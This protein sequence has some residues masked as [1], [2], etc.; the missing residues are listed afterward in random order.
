[1]ERLYGKKENELKMFTSQLKKYA[2]SIGA[3]LV[4]I[5]DP[6]R[7]ANAPFN[8]TPHAL[9]PD[10]TAAIVM[11]FHYLDTCV[12]LGGQPDA[13]YPGPAVS[14][15]IASEHANYAAFK[16]CKYIENQ[17]YKALMVPATGWWNYRANE[18]SPR[19]FAADITHYYA[20]CAAGLGEIGWNNICMTPEFGPRQRWITVVTNAPLEYDPMYDGNKLCDGCKLCERHCPGEVFSKESDGTITIDFVE[21]SYTFKHKNLWRCAL[22]ENFQLDSFMDRPEKSDEKTME[23]LCED[24]AKGGVEKRFSWKMGMCL[25]WC[26]THDRR[27]FDRNFTSSPRRRRDVEADYTS[28]GITNAYELLCETSRKIGISKVIIFDEDTLSENGI[29]LTQYVSTA[30][31]AVSVIQYYP[32]NC[33]GDTTRQCSRNALWL[34]KVLENRGGYDTM[35]E[36]GIDH[37]QVASMCRE[38]ISNMPYKIHTIITSIPFEYSVVDFHSEKYGE[39]YA[40][41]ELSMI[42]KNIAVNNGADLYGVSGIDRINKAAAQINNIIENEDYF[43]SVEQGWGEKANRMIDMKGKPKNPKVVDIKLKA[44]TTDDYM[45][46]AKAVIVIGLSM[47]NG[48]VDNVMQPPAYKGAH[49]GATVHKEMFY[50]NHEIALNVCK[51]LNAN[52]YKAHITDDL[53]DISSVTYSFGLP[54]IR[55]NNI[56]ALCAGLGVMGKNGQIINEKFG[57]KVRYV[58][59]ITDAELDENAMAEITDLRCLNCDKCIKACP[60]QA[61]S[62]TELIRLEIEGKVCEFAALDR[63]RCDWAMRYGLMKEAGPKCLG[64]INDYPVPELITRQNLIETISGSDRLQISNF[65]PIVEKCMIDCPYNK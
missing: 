33:D 64:S 47:L 60:A 65:A 40:T 35:V 25:K 20:A 5:A 1:M 63:L 54:D 43:V 3:D 27:Y 48:S 16:L 46:D 29:D 56:P 51:V 10:C 57:S 2:K 13:R 15:H 31:S 55:A 49:Y 11:G 18:A 59:I 17:G 9:M 4:G 39:K 61:L 36:S 24:W 12:E 14:N 41:N 22:G 37:I 23:K 7:W 53:L 26:M 19:G 8:R 34:A 42:L 32:E 30:K 50:Q 62:N 44:K 45:L 58:A 21:K 28:D 38:E 6:G 52:G